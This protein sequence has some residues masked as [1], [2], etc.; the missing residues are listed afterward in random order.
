MFRGTEGSARPKGLWDPFAFEA[1]SEPFRMQN[2]RVSYYYC[3]SAT[4][5]R[6]SVDPPGY[7]NA[8]RDGAVDLGCHF[9]EPGQGTP[10]PKSLALPRGPSRLGAVSVGRAL[11]QLD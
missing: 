7:V 9:L 11:N 8:L 5:D 4:D 3:P 1:T 10:C 2:S 6:G